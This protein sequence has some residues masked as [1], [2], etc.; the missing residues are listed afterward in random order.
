MTVKEMCKT[1]VFGIMSDGD[2]FVVVNDIIV[3]S[4]GNFDQLGNMSEDG[5]YSFYK[6][7]KLVK[8]CN[9]FQEL[10]HL[11]EK[12]IIFDRS[13]CVEMTLAEVRE[14]LNMPHLIIKD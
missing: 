14:K 6:V 13:K 1:G 8:N 4:N 10:D 12:D 7:E 5:N 11:T 2:K 9:S 3:Y